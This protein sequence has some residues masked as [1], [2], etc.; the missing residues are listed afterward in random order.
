MSLRRDFAL[1]LILGLRNVPFCVTCSVASTRGLKR[2]SISAFITRDIN[3]CRESYSKGRLK[4][5]VR[6][7]YHCCKSNNTQ[8]SFKAHHK[9]IPPSLTIIS[10]TICIIIHGLSTE[11]KKLTA[12]FSAFKF[13][14]AEWFVMDFKNNL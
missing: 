9:N 7:S 6:K 12:D 13:K 1:S 4:T 14:M 3:I 11:F 5:R 2:I 10:G 8:I